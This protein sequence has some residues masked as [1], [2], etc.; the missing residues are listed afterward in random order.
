MY[1]HLRGMELAL[2]WEEFRETWLLLRHEKKRQ[3]VH[4]ELFLAFLFVV[5]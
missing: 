3:Q 5:T 4:L 1:I 2:T